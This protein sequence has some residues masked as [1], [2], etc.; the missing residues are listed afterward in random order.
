MQKNE[1]DAGLGQVLVAY[2]SEDTGEEVDPVDLYEQIA[3]DAQQYAARG[4]WIASMSAVPLRHA[5]AFLARE[6]SGYETKICVTV[7]YAGTD[8]EVPER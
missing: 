1:W 8:L 3:K 6:G 2:V 5:G 4:L 7:V